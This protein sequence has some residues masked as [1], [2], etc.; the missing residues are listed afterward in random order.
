MLRAVGSRQL[1]TVTASR[2][3]SSSEFCFLPTLRGRRKLS[4]NP[5]PYSIIVVSLFFSII[6]IKPRY[7]HQ[8]TLVA[9][10]FPLSQS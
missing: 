8:Y 1:G 2:S 5:K 10:I 9:S 4:V 3:H 7:I 6:S